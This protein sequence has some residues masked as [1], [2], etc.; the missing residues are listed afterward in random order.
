[1]IN[2]HAT[3]IE[4]LHLVILQAISVHKSYGITPILTNLTIQVHV[5]DKIG[6]VG[7]NGAGKS[8]FLKILAGK[9]LPDSGDI[10]INKDK[11]LCYLAQDSGLD[12]ERIIWDE[13][14]S[15]FDELHRMEQELRALEQQMATFTNEDTQLEEIMERYSQ[16]QENFDRDGGHQLEANIRNILAGLGFGDLPYKQLRINQC[17][18]GQKTRIALA[19]ILL[20]NPDIILLDEPTNYL[21]IDALT[22]LEQ[23]IKDFN[24]AMLVVSHDRYFLDS[25]VNGIYEIDNHHGCKYP[26]SYSHYIALKEQRLLEQ[27]K[28][29]LQQQQEIAKTQDFIQRNI[30]RATT[31]TRAKSR[32]KQLEKIER[33]HAPS[34]NRETFFSFQTKVRSGNIALDI[35]NLGV[36]F[37][38][39]T[40]D[41][42]SD[43]TPT[44]LFKNL[45]MQIERGERVAIIGPN[46]TGKST[47]LKIISKRLQPTQGEIRYGSNIQVGYYDQ[48]Q[49][50][51]KMSNTAFEEVHDAFPHMTKTE[52]RS[53]LAQFLFQGDD[54]D[55]NISILSG[56]E[57]AR[58][59]LTKLM[60]AQD[61]LLLLDEPTNHLDIP[62]KEALENALMDY[63]GTMIFVSH[64]RY[65]LNQMA[66]RIV[67]MTN[68]QL[69]SYLGNYDYY[70]EKKQQEKTQ[71]PVMMEKAA[72]QKETHEDLKKRRN[73]EK[74]LERQYERVEK[75]IEETETEIAEIEASLCDPTI[76]DDHIAI[77]ELNVRLSDKQQ[78]LEKLFEEWE[79]LALEKEKY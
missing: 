68:N 51:L 27:E 60:L 10:Q 23:F 59:T 77:Q 76:F 19:K 54:V 12:S 63:D 75:V 49:A 2:Q 38:N 22:W 9:L 1:M 30:A 44:C 67:Y 66:T 15:V 39:Q 79:Q 48:E 56:G 58:V 28:L 64:D 3:Y 53:A 43:T 34:R 52:V 73:L 55:K 74:Q 26:G 37:T 32:R 45:N 78:Q 17:S 8:T 36:T 11:K 20:S 47:L 65:F 25:F 7:P 42:Q 21:D 46:G 14:L 62:A 69:Q 71:V 29:F 31:S 70:L 18:G 4:V 40:I 72:Q 35:C 61:N 33:I 13:M 57:K 5:K 50:D 41:D 6:V 16:L 24:G